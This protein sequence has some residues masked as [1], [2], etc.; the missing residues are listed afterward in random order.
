MKIYRYAIALIIGFITIIFLAKPAWAFCGFYVAK[1]ERSLYNKAS[2]VII[3]R[4]G[5]RSVLTMANDY[6]GNV[7]D[8][9]VVVPVPV[10]LEPGQV[11]VGNPTILE[12]LDAFSA[13][14]LVEYFDENPCGFAIKPEEMMRQTRG[15]SLPVSP[16]NQQNSALGVTVEKQ[17]TVGEYDIVILSAR[18]SDGLE[19]WLKQNNYKIPQ[20]ASQLLQPYIRE[21]MK[22]FVAK[23]NL[24][25]YADAGF[26]S[27]RPLMMAYESP[28]FRLPIR[29]GMAN[30]KNDQDLI[31]YLLSPQGQAELTNYRTVKVP[32]DV[33]IPEFVKQ[34]FNNFYQSM[35]ETAYEKTGKKVAFL[36]YAWDMG[37]CD[38]CSAQPLNIDEL[39]QAG[40]F[41]LDSSRLSNIFITRLHIR[42]TRDKF[43]EDLQ[44]QETANRQS[45]QGRYIIRHPFQEEVSCKEAQNYYN[46]VK[47]R[48][49]KEA[50]TLAKLTGWNLDEIR[51]KINFVST[52]SKEWWRGFGR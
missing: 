15:A 31:V 22:F 37:N 28:K 29:L 42:Y 25:E 39:R 19:T 27:L 7:K 46:S 49:E 36:E 6:Q 47:E 1:A 20:G 12:R 2:Q 34:D 8:F 24:Q 26:K 14:R 18:E 11:Q 41:W 48:Q 30:A 33:E 9:A 44:F 3:A 5:D 40:V 32:S 45:F 38:P 13:P 52:K 23:V 21:G 35:F 51:S 4:N 17:F 50:Q 43:P 10:I 16:A